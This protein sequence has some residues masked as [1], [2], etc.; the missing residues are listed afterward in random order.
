MVDRPG[1]TCQDGLGGV[2][3]ASP[4]LT[5]AMD[6]THAQSWRQD[7]HALAV[8]VTDG[9]GAGEGQ[10]VLV[11]T[12]DTGESLT[13]Y[14]GWHRL[15]PP[16]PGETWAAYRDRAIFGHPLVLDILNRSALMQGDLKRP[17]L[18]GFCPEKRTLEWWERAHRLKVFHWEEPGS[19]RKALQYYLGLIVWRLVVEL[20]ARLKA[21]DLGDEGPSHWPS[22][23]T[24]GADSATEFV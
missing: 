7:Y 3:T 14:P 10:T 22:R 2:A 11:W 6:R 12:G 8:G 16:E 13:F 5:S 4:P 18:D 23:R 15:P 17:T 21:G 24:G 1:R 20:L 9:D 19:R